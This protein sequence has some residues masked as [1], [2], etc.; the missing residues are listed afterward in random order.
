MTTNY[1]QVQID[2]E[3]FILQL[4]PQIHDL[5]MRLNNSRQKLTTSKR[6]IKLNNHIKGRR[7]ASEEELDKLTT[8]E[9]NIHNLEVQIRRYILE[10]M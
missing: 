8:L 2:S 6:D 5:V 4:T 3:T 9:E 7:F 1:I 10:C